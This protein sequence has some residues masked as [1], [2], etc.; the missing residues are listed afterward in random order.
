[1]AAS[2]L[3]AAGCG[4]GASS[5]TLTDA[6]DKTV[7]SSTL[8][9]SY[10]ATLALASVK[11]TISFKGSGVVDNARHRSRLSID[12]AN[13][14]SAAGGTG[15]LRVFRGVEVVDSSG[16][17]V[18]YLRIPFYSQRLPRPKTWLKIDYGRTLRERGIAINSLTLNQDPGQY[19]EF[20]RAASG[21]VEKIG[22]EQIG[23]VSTKHYHGSIALLEYP[24]ALAG[25][26]RNVAEH[27]A[28]RIVQLTKKSTFPTDVWVD[29][30]GYVRQMTFDYGIPASDS[31]PQIDYKL[32]LR[33]SGF[34]AQPSVGLP[35]PR[36]VASSSALR[37]S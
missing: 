21:K 16:D 31:T 28:D 1:M 30:E 2:P 7:H 29:E 8:E 11:G 4:G 35:P 15:D 10:D 25:P 19:L 20:L 36:E 34:G 9:A 27:V 12:L 13:L 33:Y 6:A 37:K 22:E 18:I 3:V 24:Q 23:G 5:K 32:T 26:R 14:A 17:V